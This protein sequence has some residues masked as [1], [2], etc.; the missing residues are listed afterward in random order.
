MGLNKTIDDNIRAERLRGFSQKVPPQAEEVRVIDGIEIS[1]SASYVLEKSLGIDSSSDAWKKIVKIMDQGEYDNPLRFLQQIVNNSKILIDLEKGTFLIPNFFNNHD[2]SAPGEC[3]TLTRRLW[4]MLQSQ[5]STLRGGYQL[6]FTHCTIANTPFNSTSSPHFVLGIVNTIDILG[7]TS[8]VLID[9]SFKRIL[10]FNEAVLKGYANFQ[11]TIYDKGGVIAY[12]DN[13]RQISFKKDDN[14]LQLFTTT[15]GAI[16]NISYSIGFF[17]EPSEVRPYIMMMNK[18]GEINLVFA[19]DNINFSPDTF[20]LDTDKINQIQEML[21]KIEFSYGPIDYVR[22]ILLP[23]D[24]C[25]SN[26][27]S[28]A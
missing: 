8:G 24:S 21:R 16:S 3:S 10:T 23:I 11:H 20:E 28:E 26:A 19:E 14:S 13:E 12:I 15:L 2:I 22:E 17:Q 5:G 25:L 18:N 6:R 9:P 1:K 27:P 7:N 4:L